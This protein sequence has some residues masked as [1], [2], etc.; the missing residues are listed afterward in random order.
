MRL[1]GAKKDRWN[2]VSP[3]PE[4]AQSIQK[5]LSMHE[6]QFLLSPVPLTH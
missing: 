6:P 5:I 2:A 1:K 4:R 3:L